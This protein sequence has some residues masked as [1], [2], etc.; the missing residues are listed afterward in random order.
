MTYSREERALED[1]A[2]ELRQIRK[3]LEYMAQAPI[4][5]HA[6]YIEDENGE[7]DAVR[8]ADI[9]QEKHTI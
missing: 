5:N 2:K 3:V 6:R 1:I 7:L 4:F 8:T 9:P